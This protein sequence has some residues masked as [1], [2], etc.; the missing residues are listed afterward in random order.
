MATTDS[1]PV[2]RKN[3]AFRAHFDLRL[4]TGA[5]CSGATGLDSEVSKDDGTFADC[6]NEATEVATSS[7]H[8][9]LDLTSTEMNA[10]S[11]V[12]QVKFTTT[13]NVTR[14]IIMHPQ[15]A[16]DIKGD[17]QTWLAG[18]IPAPGTT[19]VPS[20]DTLR[21]GGTVQTA[22]DIGSSVLL[23]SGTGAGQVSFASGI[24]SVNATQIN[25]SANA[26]AR[27]ALASAH[28]VPFTV[29]TT[30]FAGSS[31]TF[32]SNLTEA[33]AD[34]YKNGVIKWLTGALADQSNLVEASVLASGLVRFT[35]SA[36][37]DVPANGDTGIIV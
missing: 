4:N 19:G 20:V 27:L 33:T 15:E 3:V 5:L 18:T 14:T 1:L 37:T 17:V 31:T 36:M 23:S 21:I 16:G 30:G 24:L 11:V 28:M 29:D 2:P 35:M 6:T 9:Y 25:G 22:R 32:Q 8:Y 7:G 34:H 13:N 26:A 12:V 10:D